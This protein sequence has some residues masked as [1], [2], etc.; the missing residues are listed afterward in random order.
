MPKASLD[1][2]A[3]LLTILVNQTEKSALCL[4]R[5][6]GR[7]AAV[8][9]PTAESLEHL[10]RAIGRLDRVEG[11]MKDMITEMR[12]VSL[13]ATHMTRRFEKELDELRA[14]LPRQAGPGGDAAPL[15]SPPPREVDKGE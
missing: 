7:M 12:V 2:L 15:A 3:E 8:D 14:R 4:E 5:I 9:A 13:F 1:D 6:E 11:L 10:R